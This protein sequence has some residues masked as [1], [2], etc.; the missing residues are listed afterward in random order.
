MID[1]LKDQFKTTIRTIPRSASSSTS[2]SALDVQISGDHY[3]G[4]GIQPVE[5]I[6]ENNLDYFQGNVIKYVTR[7]RDKN[8][9]DDLRKAMHYLQLYIE[10]NQTKGDHYID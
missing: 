9:I 1:P 5:Y 8:G 2:E 10:F 6:W 4:C 7:W 3:K